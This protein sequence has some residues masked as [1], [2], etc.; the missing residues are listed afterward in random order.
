MERARGLTILATNRKDDFDVAFLRRLRF[1]VDF[2]RPDE[3]GRAAIWRQC[4]PP[5]ADT[6]AVDVDFLARRF[7]LTGGQIR[8]ASFAACLQ[9][10]AAPGA[11]RL[12]MESLVVAV[13]RELRKQEHTVGA[14]L[15]GRFAEL[16]QSLEAKNV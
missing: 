2:P 13:W 4:L 6:S 9:C 11:A 10:A 14:G 1:S 3:T 16:I 8:S 12:T 15:F 7:P 5:G